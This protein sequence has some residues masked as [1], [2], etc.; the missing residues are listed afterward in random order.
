VGTS[1]TDGSERATSVSASFVYAVIAAAALAFVGI[2]FRA[3]ALIHRFDPQINSRLYL[4]THL[5]TLLCE[6]VLWYILARSAVRF[7][8]YAVSVIESKDG[9][10]LNYIANAVALGLLYAMLFGMASTVKTI[11]WQSPDLTLITSITNLLPLLVLLISSVY[12]LVGTR[13]LRELLVSP[14]GVSHTRQYVGLLLV[15]VAIYAL[16]FYHV[17]AHLLDDD[18]LHHFDLSPGVLLLVYVLPHTVAWLLGLFSCLNL[19]R[20]ARNVRGAIY[21]S[22][23]HDLYMGVT[24]AFIGMYLAQVFYVSN[25]SSNQFSAGL[26]FVLAVILLLIRGCLLIYSGTNKLYTLER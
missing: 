25:L 9:R 18:G 24:I 12:L 2:M 16:Y 4:V 5:L 26:V 10:A 23:F 13:A 8:S 19:A 1:F 15:F 3:A 14:K 17:A 7:K 11:F 6:V 21:K 20:Y 22:L